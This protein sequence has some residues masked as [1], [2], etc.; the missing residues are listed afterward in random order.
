[1]RQI[2]E[3]VRERQSLSR[4]IK[5]SVHFAIVVETIDLDLFHNRAF[6][7]QRFGQHLVGARQR[8]DAP[9]LLAAEII[10]QSSEPL[11]A[12]DHP[13]S[14]EHD[15]D[16]VVV[17]FAPLIAAVEEAYLPPLQRLEH[18]SGRSK[19]L[20]EKNALFDC[21]GFFQCDVTFLFREQ[22]PG[23]FEFGFGAG[24]GVRLHRASSL[25]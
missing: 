12:Q 19:L 13:M 16:L 11:A 18:H 15:D 9:H 21:C 4:W 8:G 2:P 6:H 24:R 17:A 20:I 14:A 25:P 22:F 23:V 1:M 5:S 3:R 7:F 10:R